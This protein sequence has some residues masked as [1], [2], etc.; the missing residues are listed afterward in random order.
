LSSI[1]PRFDQVVVLIEENHG[2]DAVIGNPDA[3]YLNHLRGR[4]AYFTHMHG[5][6]HPSQ[7]NYLY[8]FSGDNHGVTDNTPLADK[9]D[10]PNL[11]GQ[12]FA[13]GLKFKGFAQSLPIDGFEGAT[14]GAYVRKHN[15]WVNFADVP[16]GSNLRFERFPHDAN[17]YKKLPPVSFV[18]PDEDHNMHTGT[19][20]QAD[21]FVRDNLL[22]YANWATKHNSLLIVTWDESDDAADNRIPTFFVGANIVPGKYHASLN[23]LNILRTLE[24]MHG[25]QAFAGEASTRAITEVWLPPNPAPRAMTHPFGPTRTMRDTADVLEFSL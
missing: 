13:A 2:N 8:L 21:A 22:D 23:H 17:G 3:R 19:I 20:A 14:S 1:V 10:A 9:L 12:L 11:G 5:E 4:G 7:P 6:T 18:V 24:E 15:P 16:S 25:L